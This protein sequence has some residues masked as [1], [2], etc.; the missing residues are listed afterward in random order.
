MV[1]RLKVALSSLNVHVILYFRFFFQLRSYINNTCDLKK[2][3]VYWYS[4]QEIPVLLHLH[5]ISIH[6]P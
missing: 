4:I 2:K 1:Q 5:T 3:K 6:F